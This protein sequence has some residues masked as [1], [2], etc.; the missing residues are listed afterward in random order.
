MR[1]WT[2][3]VING[4]TLKGIMNTSTLATITNSRLNFT[5]NNGDVLL[6]NLL[7]LRRAKTRRTRN[8]VL[9]LR[10]AALV[11]TFRRNTNERINSTSNK[12]NLIS[13]LTANS[14]NARNI[15]LRI[16][17]VSIRL[18]LFYLKRRD[19]NGNKNIS[20]ATN[21][22]LQRTLCPISTTFGFMTSMNAIPNG[23]GT[24]FLMA[25]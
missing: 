13:I 16:D 22:H 8:L 11:L 7:L 18:R 24:S 20:T 9:I 10:L 5:I 1:N 21:F 6:Y 12:L 14:A 3:T 19:R 17:K 25:T 23:R 15:S 4:S 2:G